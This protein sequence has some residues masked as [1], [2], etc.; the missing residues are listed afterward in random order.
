VI[1]QH[2]RI[3]ELDDAGIVVHDYWRVGLLLLVRAVAY[4]AFRFVR[5]RTGRL[6]RSSVEA[7]NS[8][9]PAPRTSGTQSWKQKLSAIFN[10]ALLLRIKSINPDFAVISQG[11]NFDGIDI[12]VACCKIGV[13]Y[14][15]VCQKASDFKWPMDSVRERMQQA[16][17]QARA[18]YFVSE[19][20]RALTER[21][22]AFRL[23]NAEIVRNPF[24]TPVDDPLPYPATPNDRLR[25]ACVARLFIFEKGQDTLLQVLSLEKWRSRKVDVGFYGLGVHK[26]ALEQAAKM[27]DLRNVHFEGFT[28][29]VT[30]IWRTH[31]ALVLPSRCEGLPLVVVEAMLCG[32]PVIVT[33]VGGNREVVDDG[34]T[35][36]VAGGTDA[37]ALD[38]AMER[39][40][41]RRNDWEQM[42][43]EAARRVRKLVPADPGGDFAVKLAAVFNDAHTGGH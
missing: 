19:H 11:E 3:S 31:H 1:Q 34:E 15:L 32:R 35:G 20:N 8:V 16:F 2:P 30:G 38:D 40:W 4:L 41:N 7:A 12:A 17:R 5:N 14:V 9:E 24:L 29:D 42:G 36:F 43:Q 18:V 33:D 37:G 10:A 22:L 23:P 26:T 13:P 39:A 25:L 6:K 28:D 27:L 21:Q